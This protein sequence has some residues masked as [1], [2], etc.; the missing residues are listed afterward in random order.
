MNRKAL[1]PGIVAIVLVLIVGSCTAPLLAI[2]DGA[3]SFDKN[4]HV[5]SP[6]TY[7]IYYDGSWS[8]GPPMPGVSTV[9]YST[10][11][12]YEE[13]FSTYDTTTSAWTQIWGHKG[14]Y[15]Y[16][17]KT[18]T[19]TLSFS[20]AWDSASGTYVA[21]SSSSTDLKSQ[22]MT[23]TLG[24]SMRYRVALLSGSAYTYTESYSQWDG[25][26]H[27]M[28]ASTEFSSDLSTLTVVIEEKSLDPSGTVTSGTKSVTVYSVASLFP[29]GMTK[30]SDMKGKTI[31]VGATTGSRT[32]YVWVPGSGYGAPTTTTVNEPFA[33]TSTMSMDL[34]YATSPADNLPVM[35]ARS[36]N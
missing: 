17:E 5:T 22:T 7:T 11:G 12:S 35:L 21:L 10:D 18:K 31:T 23:A 13:A 26:S 33:M 1:F 16:D 20:Q 30:L 27:T 24:D 36:M 28:L 34:S 19:M 6:A 8:D 4:G 25:S 2:N 9:T 14:S 29:A 15:R 3:L 32:G